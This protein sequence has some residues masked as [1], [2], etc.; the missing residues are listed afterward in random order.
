MLT[1][2]TEAMPDFLTPWIYLSIEQLNMTC[3]QEAETTFQRTLG[4]APEN[5]TFLG[6]LALAFTGQ[7]RRDE[8]REIAARLDV[9]TEMRYV[10]PTA[11]L[12][13]AMAAGDSVTAL[14]SVARTVTERDANFPLY[15]EMRALDPIR[16]TAEFHAALI[17]MTLSVKSS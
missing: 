10:S 17:S 4:L 16:E 9:L 1:G 14:A 13:A 5:P 2:M 15:R 3:W 6:L 12:L 11:R 7:G 8:A